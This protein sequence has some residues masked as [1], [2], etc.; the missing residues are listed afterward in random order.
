M[1]D[2]IRVLDATTWLS[3]KTAKDLRAFKRM[4]GATCFLYSLACCG[5]VMLFKL[6]DY[7]IEE[8]K[9]RIEE[10]EQKKG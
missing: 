2:I 10:L 1:I 5:A 4:Y 8:L 9:S 7:D 3:M 6:R